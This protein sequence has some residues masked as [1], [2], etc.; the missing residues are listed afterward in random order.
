[1]LR[2]E[3]TRGSS[4]VC[5]HGTGAGADKSAGG[6]GGGGTGAQSLQEMMELFEKRMA[7]LRKVVDASEMNGGE[8][9]EGG[10][11]EEE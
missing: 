1:M 11:G 6:G 7:D 4:D 9:G 3:A 10:R 2:I 5:L 8:M